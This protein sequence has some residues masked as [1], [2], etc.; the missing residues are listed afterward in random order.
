MAK[1]SIIA[2]G[3]ASTRYTGNMTYNGPYLKPAYV[4]FRNVASPTPIPFE[5]GDYVV[6]DR[7]GLTFRLYYVPTPKKQARRNSYGGAFVYDNVVLYA[8]TKDLEKTPFHDMSI[9]Y[10]VENHIHFSSRN[11]ASTFEN[12]QGIANRIQAC[13]DEF[14]TGE[15]E[16][17]VVDPHGDVDISE[18]KDFT[19]EGSCLDALGRIYE[20]WEGI[21]W[22]HTVE[23]GV[24]V[25]TIGAANTRSSGNT[26]DPFLYGKGNGLTAIKLDVTN[27]DEIVTRI[28]PFGSERNL[29][30]RY[31]N[32]KD[33]KDAE[34]VDIPNLMI[35]VSEWGI[36]SVSSLPDPAKAYVEPTDS[37]RVDKFGVIPKRVWF[38][39]SDG[40][41]DIY[42]TIERVTIKEVRDGKTALGEEDYVPSASVYTDENARVDEVAWA[43]DIEDSG[44]IGEDGKSTVSLYKASVAAQTRNWTALEIEGGAEVSFVAA[45]GPLQVEADKAIRLRVTPE[46][47]PLVILSLDTD[48]IAIVTIGI[49]GYDEKYTSSVTPV[50]DPSSAKYYVTLPELEMDLLPERSETISLYYQVLIEG[51]T[52]S[53]A[54]KNEAGLFRFGSV[55]PVIETFQIRIPQIGF[56][57]NDRAAQGGGMTISMKDGNCGGRSFPINK[58]VYESAT[59][60]WLLTLT[61]QADPSTDVLYPNGDGYN[62]LPGDH[63]VLLDIAMPEIY[64]AIAENRLLAA[65][66][67]LV[68]ETSTESVRY[69]PEID[70]IVM[71]SESR[72]IRE[73]MYM[74]VTD[75]DVIGGTDYVLIDSLTIAEGDAAIPTYKVVLLDKKK[76]GLVSAINQIRATGSSNSAEIQDNT[77]EIRRLSR[78]RQGSSSSSAT[79]TLFPLMYSAGSMADFVSGLY[80]GS[81]QRSIVIPSSL[82]HLTDWSNYSGIIALSDNGTTSAGTWL[83]SSSQV[84]EYVD[85]QLYRWKLPKA[86]AATTTL[87]ING[88]GAK[89]V[90]RSGTAKLTT[91]Y[92]VNSVLLL[93]YNASMNSGCF[94]VVNDYDANSYAYLRQYPT[95]T[96]AEYPILARY[97]TTV[98]SGSYVTEYGRY[99]ADVT[100]NPSTGVITAG[101]L[102]L[103]NGGVQFKVNPDSDDYVSLGVITGNRISVVVPGTPFVTIKNIPYT[104]EV[105]TIANAQTV[106]GAKTFSALVTASAGLF[107]DAITHT[108]QSDLL[109]GNADR[110]GWVKFREDACS[111]LTEEVTIEGDTEDVPL[112]Q[113]FASGEAYFKYLEVNN[114]AAS[115][116]SAG[117]ISGASLALT[118]AATI[119]GLASLNGGASIPTNKTFTLGGAT[120]SWDAMNNAWHLA[121]N[122]YADGYVSSGAAGQGGGGGTSITVGTWSDLQA[123]TTAPTDSSDATF[124]ARSVYEI[125]Q[126]V[127]PL[128]GKTV[129]LTAD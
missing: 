5:V 110:L 10:D 100:V 102:K 3:G 34:S 37:T 25:I 51:A 123:A 79:D 9:L 127:K 46:I 92:G 53:I 97:N 57:L 77:N 33:I 90:Y 88:L 71:A 56:D 93:V 112:W 31:Y 119:G 126:I 65:A 20:T 42:P 85:G 87:N 86:G 16:I 58:C 59:D 105:V 4:E 109:I 67:A 98:A 94:F 11:S 118:G 1:Y 124:N 40:R 28:Y 21:G 101:G 70:A 114:G 44:V 8:A 38:D 47:E 125:Y 26:S 60:S 99:A 115:I 61:R 122:F 52:R 6:Y 129:F 55:Y 74:E 62:I 117:A 29:P 73:G 13:L 108:S 78:A 69:E 15:W 39:G 43:T 22:I 72:S 63:F 49:S 19:I 83:A 106:T 91:Q 35:P 14:H 64:V 107:T 82:N 84:T 2:K 36:D 32:R 23:S 89:T 17:R 80:N 54:V 48:L 96:D 7:L 120:L 116:S 81:A 111:Y 76:T 121:G 75:T 24:N 50:K 95:T 66:Q 41:E 12:V 113:I 68:D 104:D 128:S 18:A 27:K 30:N 103:T 45:T